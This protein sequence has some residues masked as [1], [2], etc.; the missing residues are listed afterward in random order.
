MRNIPFAGIEL[1]SQ[2]VRGLRGTS[3]LPGRPLC[4]IK[5]F[6][7]SPLVGHIYIYFFS[8]KNPVYW[9]RTHAPTCQKVTRLPLC[10]RGDRHTS[11]N[12]NNCFLYCASFDLVLCFRS[13]SPAT[14]FNL[15]RDYYGNI[16]LT[17]AGIAC[18]KRLTTLLCK[19]S[20]YHLYVTAALISCYMKK[21]QSAPRPSEHPPVMG[22]EMS[23]RF[24]G[25]IKGCKYK[26]SSW[27]LNR[28][29]DADNIGSTV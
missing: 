5:R 27:H 22:G 7:R 16:L 1:T 10:Y 3:E 4:A 24:L 26:T 23:K 18:K 6:N 19:T 14:G 13:P 20:A 28:F 9:D 29:P 12:S 17:T 2:R 11:T 8:E 25:G 21:N 15:N